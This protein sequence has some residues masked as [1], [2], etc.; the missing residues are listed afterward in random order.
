MLNAMA[1]ADAAKEAPGLAAIEAIRDLQKKS[2]YRTAADHR[3]HAQ[4][5]ALQ[6]SQAAGSEGF[7]LLYPRD[8]LASAPLGPERDD[9]RDERIGPDL[10]A[11]IRVFDEAG[12]LMSEDPRMQ[13]HWPGGDAKAVAAA[14]LFEAARAIIAA[15]NARARQS[16]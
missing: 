12:R 4:F 5:E 1:K 3:A 14:F 16:A 7:N 6:R 11:A 13:D 8:K 15:V 10:A 9:A 2:G